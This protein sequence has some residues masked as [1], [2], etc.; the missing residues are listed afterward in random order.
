MKRRIVDLR[1]RTPLLD[2]ASYGR[3]G[4]GHRPLARAEIAHISRTARRVPE[5][6]VK[7]SGGARTL[8][9]VQEHLDY[10]GR[11]GKGL[12]ET[13]DGRLLQ[14]KGFQKDL[15]EDWDLDLQVH[16]RYTQRAVAAGRRPPKLVHNL[17]FSMPRDTP[18]DKLLAAARR[19][20]LEKFALQHRYVMAVHT[21]Q[22]HPHVHMVVKAVSEQGIRLNIRK[23]TLREWRRDFAQYLRDVGIEA[24][25][26]ERAV[27][28]EAKSR[29]TDGIHRAILRGDSKHMRRRVTEVARE[30]ANG[31]LKIEPGK[32]A[33]LETRRA[34]IAGWSGLAERLDRE[35]HRELA[36]TVRGFADGMPPPRTEKE[37]I[38]DRLRAMVRTPSMSAR[39][40]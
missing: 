35:G 32:R 27:R 20:A 18:S 33:I 2:I 39:T 14:E 22:G 23:A 19:F 21:D 8:R 17:V 37:L 3:R 25:A 11:E 16:R 15:V 1:E 7:V 5:V 38:A 13:D 36:V 12:V 30:L 6:V 34:V 9:G 4:S 40:L 26:T 29:K 24:N 28:G 10:I 31:Q